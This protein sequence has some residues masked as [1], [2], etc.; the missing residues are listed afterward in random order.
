MAMVTPEDKK[1]HLVICLQHAHI[2][3]RSWIDALLLNMSTI[4]L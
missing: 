1:S 4:P 2:R 3:E